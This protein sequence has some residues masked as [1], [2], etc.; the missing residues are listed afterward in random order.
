MIEEA[1]CSYETS[2][3][4]KE[5]GFD[6]VMRCWYDNYGEFHE[7]GCKMRN[8]DCLP[9]TIMAPTLAF[10]MMWLREVHGWHI[11]LEPCYDYDSMHVIYLAFVQ[12]V[13]DVHTFM[14]GR[15]NVASH[16]Q[17]ESAAEFAI[18]YCLKNLITE[19]YG[20]KNH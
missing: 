4:L 13:A 20:N 14:D 19:R 2:K 9:L 10:A 17:A 12:N 16:P 18:K 5:K 3:L 8:S 6:E 11:S 15:K 1:Y 7:D